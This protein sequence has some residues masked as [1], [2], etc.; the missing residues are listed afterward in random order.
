MHKKSGVRM[1]YANISSVWSFVF[2]QY[3]HKPWFHG[4]VMEKFTG[5][6]RPKTYQASNFSRWQGKELHNRYSTI[7]KS[8][9]MWLAKNTNRSYIQNSYIHEQINC[10]TNNGYLFLC[11]VILPLSNS[12][13]EGQHYWSISAHSRSSGLIKQRNYDMEEE[14]CMAKKQSNLKGN[15]LLICWNLAV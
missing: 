3:H 8:R 13:K 2:M 7:I 1:I 9:H 5:F 6:S 14:Q 11:I 4:W 10:T 15:I 12:R